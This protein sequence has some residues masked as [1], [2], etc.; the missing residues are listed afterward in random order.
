MKSPVTKAAYRCMTVILSAVLVTASLS[1]TG[2]SLRSL[3]PNRDKTPEDTTILQP[4]DTDRNNSQNADSENEPPQENKPV[5]PS[6]YN[7]L[8]GLAAEV[9]LSLARPVAICLGDTGHALAPYGLSEAEI[10]IEAPA[11]SGK[12]K[13]TFLTSTYRGVAQLGAIGASR[14][15]LLSFADYFGAVSVCAGTS[16]LLPQEAFVGSADVI[17]YAKEGLSTVFYR[18]E[19]M[20]D[21][22]F[23]SGTRLI[24]A[25][26]NYEKAG[27][28]LPYALHPYG[29]MVSPGEQPATGVVIP[30]AEGHVT[31]FTYNQESKAY[32]CS[33]NAA[34]QASG[35]ADAAAFTNLLL[36]VCESSVHHKVS[37]TEFE[38]NTTGGGTG[39]YVSHGSYTVI[40][41]AKDGDGN[42]QITDQSGAPLSV[43]RGKTYIGLVD[44][45]ESHSLL[46]IK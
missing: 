32:L 5:L 33:Q 45:A 36:L 34:M 2:C 30:Y 3:I 42:L 27:P 14:P 43:N 23:T 39:Y 6:Y 20:P 1:M 24:G 37:G 21:K 35:N 10:V 22:L 26:E 44:L 19:E 18:T 9:D 8:T 29:T 15:Y 41:W 7:P 31:Q 12:T 28:R 25:L 13:L 40:T 38:L 16:D 17:D 4:E 46:L 11:E